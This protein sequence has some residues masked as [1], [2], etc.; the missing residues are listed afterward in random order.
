MKFKCDFTLEHYFETLEHAQEEFQ[1]GPVKNFLKKQKNEK[2]IFLRH[3]VDFSLDYALDLAQSEEKHGF[4]STFFIL[5]HSD[6][7]NPYSVKGKE[8]ISKI[9]SLGHEIGLH[10]DTRFL[11]K[12]IQKS[13]EQIKNQILTLEDISS[14]CVISAAPHIPSETQDIVINLKELDILNT[15]GEDIL[16]DVFYISDSGRYWRN[17][18]MCSHIGKHSSIQILTHP[19]WWAE[20]SRSIKKQLDLFI[21]RESTKLISNIGDYKKMVTRLLTELHAPKENFE[22]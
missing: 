19:I 1:I 20:N 10:Y 15:R 7:Y 21:E 9:A 14:S 5:L 18:C 11:S 6:F 2:N 4:C 3:D 13:K 8:V 12:D 16:K 17:G 22:I